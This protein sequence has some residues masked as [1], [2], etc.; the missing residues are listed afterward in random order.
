MSHSHLTFFM[1]C[2]NFLFGVVSIHSIFEMETLTRSYSFFFFP[3]RVVIAGLR[4]VSSP[5]VQCLVARPG[6]VSHFAA[7]GPGGG[8]RGHGRRRSVPAAFQVCGGG[9][10]VPPDGDSFG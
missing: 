1:H 10:G 6:D 4:V 3:V 2:P 8:G 9:L 7:G 5:A